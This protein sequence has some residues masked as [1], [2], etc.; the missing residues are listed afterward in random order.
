MLSSNPNVSKHQ[1]SNPLILSSLRIRH[2]PIPCPHPT[3][4]SSHNYRSIVCLLRPT[5]LPDFRFQASKLDVSNPFFRLPSSSS[6]PHPFEPPPILPFIYPNQGIAAHARSSTQPNNR[7]PPS[8]RAS[9]IEQSTTQIDRRSSMHAS[10]WN[11]N[12]APPKH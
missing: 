5:S 2:P 12:P 7:V 3:L 4:T 10:E 11:Y 8:H 9:S 6:S 1:V